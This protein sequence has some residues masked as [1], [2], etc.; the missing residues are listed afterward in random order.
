MDNVSE[1]VTL[2]DPGRIFMLVMGIVAMIMV[3]RL[4]NRVADTTGQRF[5]A[6]RLLIMQITTIIGFVVYI[7]G[8]VGLVTG[9]L[10]PSRELLLTL[11]GSLAVAI[12]FSLK[13]LVS[14]LIAGLILLFDRPFQVGDR[15]SF[16]DIYGEIKSIGL[17]AVRLVT[18]DDNLVTIP[19][20]KFITDSVASGNSGALDMMI[21][22]DFHI[23]LESDVRLAR[24][25][26]FETVVTS[27][28]AYL[29]KPVAV[30]ISETEI[31]RRLCLQLKVKAYVL[32]VQ[33]EKAFQSDL[34]LRG[35]E[36][37]KRHG[38]KRP[39]LTYA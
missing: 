30:V 33:Y 2:F 5:P 26:L 18:L 16:G 10:E 6:R 23:D 3:V 31:A 14:S 37:F 7:A 19:N 9:V 4:L 35:N 17:R 12:G 22:V 39:E 21:T 11:G 34:V 25:L 20:S 8:S 13:D 1:I 36:V 27:R 38:I 15:V 28:F 29:K 32:D 24:Q